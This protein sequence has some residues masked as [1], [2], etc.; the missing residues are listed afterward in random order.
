MN[1]PINAAVQCTDGPGGRSTYVIVNPINEQVTHL[2]VKERQPPHTERLVPVRFVKATTP[3]QVQ[4]S[5]NLNELGRLRPFVE[6]EFIRVQAPLLDLQGL[7]YYGDE[8]LM[9]LP[10]AKMEPPYSIQEASQVLLKQKVKAVP[11]GELAVRRG[12]RVEATDGR[13]GW[14]DE[15]VVD[16]DSGHITHLTMRKGHLWGDEEVSIP[17]SEIGRIAEDVVYLKLGKRQIEAL[18]VV[19]VRRRWR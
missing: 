5:C 16:P 10:Y 14:V 18:P 8:D 3:E 19:Q 13:V 9:S 17:V 15:F 1:I 12:A 2:V 6:I 4:L 7:S 11:P